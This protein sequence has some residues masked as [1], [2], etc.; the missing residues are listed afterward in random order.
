MAGNNGGARPGAGRKPTGVKTK[1]YTVTLPLDEAQVLEDHAEELDISV[2]KYLRQ[3][4]QKAGKYSKVSL[5]KNKS[6]KDQEEKTY[7]VKHHKRSR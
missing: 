7:V 2:N 5:P 6:D 3:L 1:C 4:I